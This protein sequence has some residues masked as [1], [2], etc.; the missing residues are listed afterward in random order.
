MSKCSNGN[1]TREAGKYKQCATCRESKRKSLKKRKERASRAIPEDGH[2]YCMACARQ[3]PLE[4]FHSTVNRRKKRTANCATCRLILSKSHRG[5]GS[6][7]GQCKLVYEQW[8]VGKICA[9]CGIEGGLLEADHIDRSTK[10][11]ACSDYSWWAWNGGPE[12]QKEELETKCRP[13]HPE[14]HAL[15]TKTQLRGGGARHASRLQKQRYVD[16]AKL[17][18]SC[19]AL[20]KKKVTKETVST[21]EF[22]H[23]DPDIY[24]CRIGRMVS[25]YAL[26]IFYAVVDREMFERCRLLC[27]SCHRTHTNSQWVERRAVLERLVENYS[28]QLK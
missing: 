13:A 8:K 19:C 16:E 6:V 23:L 3:W 28:K 27:G 1:C 2:R 10:V 9:I 17:K 18:I 12:K 22:D 11:R 24:E 5:Q 25:S 21:F 14:C 26:K 20:C 4:H 7:R 15:H